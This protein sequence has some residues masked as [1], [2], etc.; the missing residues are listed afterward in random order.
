MREKVVGNVVCQVR[1]SRSWC[2]LNSCDCQKENE[3]R[4]RQLEKFFFFV[5]LTDHSCMHFM[6]FLFNL[7][8]QFEL[9]DVD[10]CFSYSVSAGRFL[11]KPYL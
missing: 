7:L 9:L 8:I 5:F 10:Y 1:T 6:Y 4:E 2:G 11:Q 3:I